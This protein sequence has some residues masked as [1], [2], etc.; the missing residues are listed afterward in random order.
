ML[1]RG[2]SGR[3]FADQLPL[4]E[5]QGLFYPRARRRI[6]ADSGNAPDAVT[7][8]GVT[9]LAASYAGDGRMT[10]LQRLREPEAETVLSVSEAE[11]RVFFL[12]G[13]YAPVLP[14]LSRSAD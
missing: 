11:V 10:G 12:N 7:L 5:A 13:S 1:R 8:E 4:F 2:F 6:A 3:E 9:V 14:V